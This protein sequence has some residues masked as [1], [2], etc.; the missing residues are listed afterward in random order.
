MDYHYGEFGDCSFSSFD[1]SAWTNTHT[2]TDA[3]KRF[4]PTTVV[5]TVN[6]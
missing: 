2:H 1:L 4:T 5:I 3:A 6:V